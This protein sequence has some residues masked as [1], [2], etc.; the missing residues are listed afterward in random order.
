MGRTPTDRHRYGHG[1]FLP[2]RRPTPITAAQG[3]ED[4]VLV[5]DSMLC[6]DEELLDGVAG[7]ALAVEGHERLIWD[8][9]HAMSDLEKLAPPHRRSR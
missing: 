6:D 8:L 7:I 4:L 9:E 3:G 5:H 1:R 2:D